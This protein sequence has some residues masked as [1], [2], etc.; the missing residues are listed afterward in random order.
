MAGK[1][2]FVSGLSG[3]GK[4]TLIRAAMQ[5][6]DTLSYLRTVT[7]RPR[8]QGEQDGVEYQFVNEQE[9]EAARA[10]SEQWDHSE[11]Q[12]YKY[13]ADVAAVRKQLGSGVA[14]ICSIAPS[15]VILEQ[16][17]H[18]FGP[19]PITVWVDT[20]IEVVKARI[21]G[22]KLRSARQENMS[23]RAEMQH[24]FTPT[25]LLADDEAAFT[26]LIRSLI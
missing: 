23:L 22:D 3:A 21:K 13:G 5:Q 26:K 24:I 18:I 12:G 19:D 2:I 1:L 11:Y 8:R 25:Y 20:S 17:K 16:M 14:V 9:Y 4:T 10:K 7:T 6:I 15:G